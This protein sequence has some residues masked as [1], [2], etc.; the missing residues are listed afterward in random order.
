MDAVSINPNTLAWSP[1][2]WTSPLWPEGLGGL[3]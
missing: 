2:I 3:R 1:K